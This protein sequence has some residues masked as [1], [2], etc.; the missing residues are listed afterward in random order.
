MYLI[1]LVSI[2]LIKFDEEYE[3]WGIE[4]DLPTICSTE[5][6]GSTPGRATNSS[7]YREREDRL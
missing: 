1:L 6:W 2:I 4:R 7:P 5:N 3:L